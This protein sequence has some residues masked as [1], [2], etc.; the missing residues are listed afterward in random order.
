VFYLLTPSVALQF[1]K[2]H[3]RLT[4]PL[5]STV[6]GFVIRNFLRSGVASTTPNPQPGGPVDYNQPGSYTLTCLAWVNLPGAYAP[7]SIA[8][9]GHQS[10]T[11]WY[12]ERPYTERS[13]LKF[14][15]P[16]KLLPEWKYWDGKWN[17]RSSRRLV[18]L[19]TV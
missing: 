2:K 14:T 16:F 17:M 18:G 1:L 3:G 5:T 7:A 11:M 19:D 4:Y 6:W 13:C 12:H 9:G 10:F 15:M 8:L